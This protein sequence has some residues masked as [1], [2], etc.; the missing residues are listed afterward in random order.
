MGEQAPD[1]SLPNSQSGTF[2]LSDL[3]GECKVVLVLYNSVC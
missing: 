3:H 2:T 1:F